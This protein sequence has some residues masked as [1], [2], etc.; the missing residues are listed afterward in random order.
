MQKIGNSCLIQY[1]TVKL[2]DE[3]KSFTIYFL[4]FPYPDK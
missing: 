3:I 4:Q 1:L 2:I